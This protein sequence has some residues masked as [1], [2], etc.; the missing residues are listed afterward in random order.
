VSKD[1]ISKKE[2]DFIC[3]LKSIMQQARQRVYT[4][5]NIFT[6]LIM[7]IV[8]AC[9]VRVPQGAVLVDEYPPIFPLYADSIVIPPNIAPL[10]FILPDSMNDA[11]VVISNAASGVDAAIVAAA[12]ARVASSA[13]V[14]IKGGNVHISPKKWHALCTS[15]STAGASVT[16]TSPA[17]Q[18]GITVTVYHNNKQYK[19]LHWFVSPDSI[20]PYI[21]YRLV[22]PTDGVYRTISLDERELSTFKTRPLM[23][24]TL[25]NDNCFNCH[26]FQNRNSNKMILQLRN[27]RGLFIKDENGIRTIVPPSIA[28]IQSARSNIA[29]PDENVAQSGLLYSCWHPT[30]DLIVFS[31]G[32]RAPVCFYMPASEQYYYNQAETNSC[33]ITYNGREWQVITHDTAE[34]S[35]PTWHPDGQTLFFVRSI[36][37][38]AAPYPDSPEWL[39]EYS[40]DLCYMHYDTVAMKFADTVYTLVKAA[41]FAQDLAR[42]QNGSG[43]NGG[44]SCCSGEKRGIHGNNGGSNSEG[45]SC[46]S[47][48]GGEN[49]SNSG[50]IGSSNQA[51]TF[52]RNG[53]YGQTPQSGGSFG[54]PRISPDGTFLIATYSRHAGNPIRAYSVLVGVPLVKITQS[55]PQL[56]SLSVTNVAP[57]A[58]AKTSARLLTKITDPNGRGDSWASFS[59]NGKWL[60]FAS[61]RIDGYYTQVWFAH[62]DAEPSAQKSNPFPL[63]QQT[64]RYYKQTP[65]AFN[66]PEF[67]T[68]KNR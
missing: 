58:Y 46:S 48:C 62:V 27:P 67:T 61:K 5:K 47:C 34:Y 65:K 44:S 25:T 52:S 50:G 33:L 56:T 23:S 20:D 66:L 17:T 13:T 2:T 18:T 31:A 41:D 40:F 16:A 37:K 28:K 59:S 26:S 51:A 10:N 24:N 32:G 6:G 68:A 8:A 38:P 45:I 14:S 53:V 39:A 29:I 60:M 55:S 15:T 43:C 57:A 19:P 22:L 63:P 4:A 7:V 21:V 49:G 30:Q 42:R 1:I 36:K 64:G 54:V 12:P 35:Y 11:V 3:K 9:G